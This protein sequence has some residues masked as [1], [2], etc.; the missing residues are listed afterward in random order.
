[1]AGQ[2]YD[3]IQK[4]VMSKSK[5]NPVIANCIRTKLFLKGISVDKYTPTSPDD[6]TVVRKLQEAASEFGV[7]I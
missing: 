1:M 3:M 5:G 4:I 7:T 2:I 6:P